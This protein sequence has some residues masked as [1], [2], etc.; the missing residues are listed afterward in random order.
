[1]SIVIEIWSMEYVK[2]IKKTIDPN[3]CWIPTFIKM[4]R[5]KD[6]Y[7]K[8]Y[9]RGRDYRLHRVVMSAKYQVNYSDHTNLPRHSIGC[10]KSCFNPDHIM[11]GS[12]RDNMLDKISH[13]NNHNV[14][15]SYC[16]IC[17]GEYT[18]IIRKSGPR[19]GMKFRRCKA[20]AK[21]QRHSFYKREGC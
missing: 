3:G 7:A 1:M 13:G 9:F 14:N 11:I 8:F 21:R 5:D 19:K 20:C 16:N 6:G 18:V 2:S 4:S 12:Q 17:G 10:Q 15:K